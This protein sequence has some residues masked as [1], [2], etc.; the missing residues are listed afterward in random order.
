MLTDAVIAERVTVSDAAILGRKENLAPL[1]LLLLLLA[2]WDTSVFAVTWR[3]TILTNSAVAVVVLLSLLLFAFVV[4][5]ITDG[6]GA[7]KAV[8]YDYSLNSLSA[9]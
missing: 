8:K 6:G 1:P 7:G 3:S 9:M 4:V 2:R 5:V